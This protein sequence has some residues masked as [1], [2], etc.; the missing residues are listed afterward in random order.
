MFCSLLEIPG[1]PSSYFIISNICFNKGLFLI[2]IMIHHPHPSHYQAFLFFFLFI[3]P[4]VLISSF[5]FEFYAKYFAYIV[6]HLPQQ[7]ML[8][9]L[10]F[11]LPSW[12]QLL[13]SSVDKPKHLV[14]PHH[15]KD[16]Q[17]STS[18]QHHLSSF[19]FYFYFLI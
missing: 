6:Y 18:F 10:K 3:F 14:H 8:L 2:R 5:V 19:Y 11:R 13:Y 17:Q 16:W 7:Y 15:L 1:K 9:P 12:L 4:L